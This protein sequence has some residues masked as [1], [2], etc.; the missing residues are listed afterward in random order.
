MRKLSGRKSRSSRWHPLID[1][2]DLDSAI[3]HAEGADAAG[4][5]FDREE[6]VELFPGIMQQRR[7]DRFGMADGD[8]DGAAT[9]IVAQL[10][11]M[12]D[13]A[14]LKRPHAFAPR[15][16]V[17]SALFVPARPAGI[18][19]ERL[20]R[21]SGPFAVVEL[22]EC[23]HDLDRQAEVRRQDAGRLHAAPLRARL[24]HAR[25]RR[26]GIG[27]SRDLLAAEIIELYAL[28]PPTERAAEQGMVPV[29]DQMN[30]LRHQVYA[31]SSMKA[32]VRRPASSSVNC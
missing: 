2:G 27:T 11:Q 23:R 28:H 9:M 19:G 29:A 14:L 8:D 21:Q 20:E 26:E 3:V 6:V 5:D 4:V 31:L 10:L 15:R 30:D 24:N 18:P 25:R 16:A 1:P 13:D 17:R 7:A 22:V 12:G 32:R